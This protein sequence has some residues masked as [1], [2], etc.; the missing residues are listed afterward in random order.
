MIQ[1]GD[2]GNMN[3]IADNIYNFIL[4]NSFNYYFI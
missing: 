4:F 2:E 1:V 3:T